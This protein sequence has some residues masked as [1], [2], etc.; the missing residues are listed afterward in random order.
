MVKGATEIYDNNCGVVRGREKSTKT[1]TL[2]SCTAGW[3]T[4][5][6]GGGKGDREIYGNKNCI[7]QLGLGHNNFCKYTVI[8]R[9]AS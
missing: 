9:H 6:C 8:V 2:L 3:A 1:N 7:V 5:I 4:E